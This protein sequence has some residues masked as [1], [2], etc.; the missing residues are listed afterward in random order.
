MGIEL[1]YH[2]I[3]AIALILGGFAQLVRMD[4]RINSLTVKVFELE[5]KQEKDLSDIRSNHDIKERAIWEK[6]EAM[7]SILLSMVQGLGRLE[8]KIDRQ[9]Q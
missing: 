1:N 8:G 5:K 3:A 7:H 6:I 2:T 4:S 9:G